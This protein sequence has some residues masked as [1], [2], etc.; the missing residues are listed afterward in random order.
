MKSLAKDA[1]YTYVCMY[2]KVRM[3]PW[4]LEEP[5]SIV[6]LAGKVV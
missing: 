4:H 6:L 5:F 3:K 1:M 2:M